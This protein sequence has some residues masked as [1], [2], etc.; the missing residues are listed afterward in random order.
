MSS[1]LETNLRTIYN[2]KKTKILPTNIKSGVTIFGVLGTYSA[3]MKTYTTETDMNNDIANIETD[4]IV[5][6]TTGNKIFIKEIIEST[7]TMTEL[8]KVTETITPEEYEENVDLADDI[9]GSTI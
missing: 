2:E 7:P 9:L 8:V 3:Q 1:G 4:E 6:V 5:R